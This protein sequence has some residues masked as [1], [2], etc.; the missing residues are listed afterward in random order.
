M[1][2]AVCG[3]FFLHLTHDKHSS[4]IWLN[5]LTFDSFFLH[6]TH[7]SYIWLILLTFDTN[8]KRSSFYYTTCGGY[9]SE[10]HLQ[11][12][13]C[14]E[15][16]K[17]KLH[18]AWRPFLAAAPAAQA[19]GGGGGGHKKRDKTKREEKMGERKQKSVLC[20]EI[21]LKCTT[22]ALS[23][24]NG[25]I[26]NNLGSAITFKCS[27]TVLSQVNGVLETNLGSAITFKCSTT[28]LSQVHGAL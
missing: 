17:R 28:V 6:L 24:M 2:V 16:E 15:K 23:Q 18:C 8:D 10:H 1:C 22:M 14:R 5:L 3:W 7:S 4:Y 27:T 12:C 26:D 11:P 19:G 20:M 25:A 9:P 21:I 13:M